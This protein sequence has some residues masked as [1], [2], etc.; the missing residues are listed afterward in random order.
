MTLALFLQAAPTPNSP[1]KTTTTEHIANWIEF[2]SHQQLNL[3]QPTASTP[4]KTVMKM[5]EIVQMWLWA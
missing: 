3:L 5:S 1:V 4:K 2:R